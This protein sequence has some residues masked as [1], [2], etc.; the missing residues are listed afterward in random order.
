MIN[1]VSADGKGV[2]LDDF[3]KIGKGKIIP[4]AGIRLPD[5]TAPIKQ[6]ILNNLS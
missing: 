1:I 3:K 5:P 4:F 6:T 2:L